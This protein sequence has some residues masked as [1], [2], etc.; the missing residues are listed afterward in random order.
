VNTVLAS[1]NIIMGH[2]TEMP[3]RKKITGTKRRRTRE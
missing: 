2:M 1:F 3:Q